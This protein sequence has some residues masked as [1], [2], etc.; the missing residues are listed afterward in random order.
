MESETRAKLSLEELEDLQREILQTRAKLKEQSLKKGFFSDIKI[1]K[2]KDQEHTL[3][4]DQALLIDRYLLASDVSYQKLAKENMALLQSD[5][6]KFK[7]HSREYSFFGSYATRFKGKVLNVGLSKISS[8]DSNLAIL[9]FDQFEYPVRLHG[10]I[11]HF[12]RI[13]L[14]TIKTKA[15]FL[16]NLPKS[17]RGVINKEGKIQLAVS[18]RETDLFFG[19]KLIISHLMARHFVDNAS[20]FE[21]FLR[22]KTSMIEAIN[23]YRDQL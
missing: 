14:K 15:S 9:P 7:V 20:G 12:G 11:D 10:T 2:L 3:M 1:T 23:Q 4:L 5:N 13:N 18:E 17:Y 19:G 16:K 21:Q 6:I 8:F 22:N